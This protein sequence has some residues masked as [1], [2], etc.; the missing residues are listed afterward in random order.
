MMN[1]ATPPHL[2]QDTEFKH[3]TYKLSSTSYNTLQPFICIVTK[4][5]CKIILVS[6]MA[7]L[8][9]VALAGFRLHLN[10]RLGD[11]MAYQRDFFKFDTKQKK[12]NYM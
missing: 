11:M 2:Y 10:L 7:A 5:I 1:A 4:W 3:G 9:R 6:G 12:K 8:Q